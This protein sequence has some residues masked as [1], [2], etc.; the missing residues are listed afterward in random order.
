MNVIEDHLSELVSSCP[1]LSVYISD[2]LYMEDVAVDSLDDSIVLYQCYNFIVKEMRKLGIIYNYDTDTILSNYYDARMISILYGTFTDGGLYDLF[3]Y[4]PHMIG[5]FDDIRSTHHVDDVLRVFIQVLLESNIIDTTMCVDNI[6]VNS[7]VS[8]DMF[9][10]RV[11]NVLSKIEEYNEVMS[12]ISSD[13]I[14][15]MFN[16]V[17]VCKQNIRLSISDIISSV[18]VDLDKVYHIT[19]KFMVELNDV[20]AQLFAYTLSNQNASTIGI[21]KKIYK[22]IA[23]QYP[24]FIEYYHDKDIDD[25]VTVGLV[26]IAQSLNSMIPKLI[27]YRPIHKRNPTVCDHM[28]E[29]LNIEVEYEE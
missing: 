5:M 19:D 4:N 20:S 2:Q 9:I 27:D 1:A 3:T 29:H 15:H 21:L 22:D 11:D 14:V 28:F 24:T 6:I 12:D 25:S 16:T 17:F 26:L 13:S 8:T 23:K 10:D 7:I 18:N